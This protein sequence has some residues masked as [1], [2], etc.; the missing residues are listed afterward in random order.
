MKRAI[1]LEQH[2]IETVIRSLERH[3]TT[4]HNVNTVAV[5][6]GQ[7]EL[8]RIAGKFRAAIPSQAVKPDA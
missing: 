1:D 3:S 6:T 2:E 5:L 7:K 8:V 4:T